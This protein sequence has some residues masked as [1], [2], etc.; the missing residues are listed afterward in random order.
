M[1]NTPLEELPLSL[2]AYQEGTLLLINKPL[3]W[4]SFDVVN[5]VR[6]ALC[7]YF[8]VKKLKVGHAG[9]LDPLATGLLIICTGKFTKKIDSIQAQEKKYTGTIRVGATTP[10]YDKES[11]IDQTLPLP[12][13]NPELIKNIEAQFTGHIMQVPPVFS[14]IKKDGK[15]SYELARKGLDSNLEARPIEIS[16]ISLDVTDWPDMKFE[17]TCSKGTYIRSLAHDIGQAMNS[18]AYLKSLHRNAIGNYTD[19]SAI[20]LNDFLAVYDR[21]QHERTSKPKRI[22]TRKK[23]A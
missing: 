11:E 4:T 8:G 5:R 3:E 21:F 6:I 20:P 2:E 15:R 7:K 14:A 19:E 16:S 23:D 18:G 17:V 1:D 10:T 12:D 22:F 9:T 13:I